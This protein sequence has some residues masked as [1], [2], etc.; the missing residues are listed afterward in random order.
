MSR[1]YVHRDPGPR[2]ILGSLAIA[3]G[4][5]GLSFYLARALLS[6]EG[7]ESTPPSTTLSGAVV[8]Q[9]PNPDGEG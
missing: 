9:A 7:L 3:L 8:R 2:E 6:R 1:Y 5:G 4:I